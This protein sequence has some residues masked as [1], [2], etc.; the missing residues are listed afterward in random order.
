MTAIRLVA[1]LLALSAALLLVACG[2]GDSHS[3]GP[4]KLEVVSIGKDSSGDEL[5]PEYLAAKGDRLW[6]VIGR[7]VASIDARTGKLATEPQP[8]GQ[9]EGIPLL[10]DI[11]AGDEGV[12]VVATAR[13]K[14]FL[15]PVDEATG[16]P[17]A[18]ITS[19]LGA[20]S[21]PA[22]SGLE[23]GVGGGRVWTA[24]TEASA[25]VALDPAAGR[26]QKIDTGAV[27]Q[28]LT[29]GAGYGW[30]VTT[31]AEEEYGSGYDDS[32]SSSGD[33]LI[34]LAPDGTQ[35]AFPVG[36]YPGGVAVQGDEV[37]VGTDASAER[38]TLEGKEAASVDLDARDVDATSIAT[39]DRAVWVRAFSENKL[40]RIDPRTN[41]LD[42]PPLFVDEPRDLAVA[43]GYVWVTVNYEPIRRARE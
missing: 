21:L 10:Y 4:R 12:W 3:D 28:D 13:D 14:T 30:V 8:V 20:V 40:L 19:K 16:R 34:R 5:D 43:G 29:G 15:V 35:K 37:W 26:Q 17:G 6:V 24:A 22:G 36:S 7:D 25:V 33:A 38:Y 31:P 23:V 2:G 32:A 11:A 9:V 18:P 27:I 42:G 1:S 39:S 41:R